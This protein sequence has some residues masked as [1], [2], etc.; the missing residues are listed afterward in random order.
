MNSLH[1]DHHHKKGA[2]LTEDARQSLAQRGERWTGLRADVFS[3]LAEQN[4]PASAYEITEIVSQKQGKRIAANSVY[5]ILDLFVATNLAK[6]VEVANAY[7]VN[8]HPGCEHDCIFL[9]C[10]KC[11]KLVHLDNDVIANQLRQSAQSVNFT[12]RRSVI[13]LVGLCAECC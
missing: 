7:I 13:E 9:L 2:D 6:R 1:T 3:A 10:E 11:Q 12:P 4:G 8:S 5:R